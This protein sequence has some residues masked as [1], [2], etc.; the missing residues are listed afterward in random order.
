MCRHW[1]L[2]QPLQ[3][4][5]GVSGKAGRGRAGSKRFQH[6]PG[7]GGADPFHNLYSPDRTDQFWA[8]FL[9]IQLG[10]LLLDAAARFGGRAGIQRLAQGRLGE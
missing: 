6:A 10:Q 9:T 2:H 3:G 1:P 4:R 7:F 8:K 5:F